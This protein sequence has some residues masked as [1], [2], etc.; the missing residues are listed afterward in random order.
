MCEWLTFGRFGGDPRLEV[1]AEKRSQRKSSR[2][3]KHVRTAGNVWGYPV[4]FET[5]GHTLDLNRLTG[6]TNSDPDIEAEY[7][8]GWPK[9][10]A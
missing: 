8:A 10:T 4:P 3:G 2:R 7:T 1:T 9:F 6:Q 5:T